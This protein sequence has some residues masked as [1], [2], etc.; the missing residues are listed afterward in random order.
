MLNYNLGSVAG[1]ICDS[2][3]NGVNQISERNDF[4]SLFPNPTYDKIFIH[5]NFSLT[6]NLILRNYLGE[7][8]L[9]E[10]VLDNEQ[11]DLS[12]LTAGIYLG[13]FFVGQNIVRRNI[14]K[15]D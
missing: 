15:D 14:L 5:L 8:V 13:E 9:E 12:S 3:S 2:V 10:L 1:S 4:V 11:L 6:A 7:I